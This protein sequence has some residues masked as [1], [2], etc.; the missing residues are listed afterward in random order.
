MSR[1]FG[2]INAYV[3]AATKGIGDM[4]L[5]LFGTTSS[6]IPGHLPARHVSFQQF[7]CSPP[8]RQTTPK[9]PLVQYL[10]LFFSTSPTP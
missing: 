9:A 6:H 1:R 5:V 4:Y 10:F 7:L 8:G 3:Q 2:D